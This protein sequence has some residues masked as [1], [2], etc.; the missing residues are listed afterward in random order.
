[1]KSLAIRRIVGYTV[2]NGGVKQMIGIIGAME[3]EIAGLIKKMTGVHTVSVGKITLTT[4]TLRDVPVVVC[5]AGIGKVHAAAAATLLC[6]RFPGVGLL[7]NLGVAGGVMPGIKQ[8]DFVVASE[9]VQHDFDAAAEGYPKGRVAGYA[10]TGFTSDSAAVDTMCAVLAK[11]GFRYE[12][13]VIAS[14]DQFIW[15]KGKASSLYTEFG[16]LACDM[17]TAA[18]AHVCDLFGKK[19]LGVR[20]VSDNADGSAPEAFFAF[21]EKAA[22]RSIAAVEAFVGVYTDSGYAG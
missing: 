12:R 16:A 1:M 13:G 10:Q 17:E 6:E 15:D 19:F 2:K 5:L 7:I 3:I 22:G 18:I 14:G 8:G 20:S 9:S 21:V 11:S 4:G